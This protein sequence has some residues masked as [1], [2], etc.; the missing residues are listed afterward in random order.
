VL[1]GI[2]FAIPP[3]QMVGV[4][5]PNGS[6][7]STTLKLLSRILRPDRGS[8]LVKGRL[9]ALIELG[10]G[11]H[12]D[13]TGRE[14]VFLN[15]SIL[16][17]SKEEIAK[18]YDQI[19]DFA[20]LHDFME[21]PVK[22]YSSGMFARLGFSVAVHTEPDILLVDEVL[23][24]GDVGFQKK[25]FEKMCEFKSKKSTTIVFVSH[26]MSAVAT[27]CDRVILLDKGQIC[28]EGQPD[29]QIGRYLTLTSAQRDT[30]F[31][32]IASVNK[33]MCYKE[34]KLPSTVFHALEKVVLDVE[35]NFKKPLDDILLTIMVKTP[36][37]TTVFGTSSSRLGAKPISVKPGETVRLSL[38][39]VWNLAPGT[40]TVRTSILKSHNSE[41]ICAKDLFT[42]IIRDDP[43]VSGVA[44]LAPEL[45][46]Y[47]QYSLKK[48]LAE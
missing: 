34:S 33:A 29:N 27:L 12:P 10:A 40:Y 2:T 38:N 26:N 31:D 14:N 8:I 23:S 48:G 35:L 37:D 46:D 36:D 32:S 25:C 18:K 15:A 42:L 20:G 30:S 45:L 4:I 47:S 19:V 39:L 13:L 1:E 16:G 6:G 43:S 41:Y 9:G 17:M 3:G 22:W 7:K 21:T 44:H 11:F 28:A 24:V 5:G